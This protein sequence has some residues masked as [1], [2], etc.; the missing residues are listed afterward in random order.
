MAYI[1]CAIWE[2]R[3]RRQE[4]KAVTELIFRPRALK[5]KLPKDYSNPDKRHFGVWVQCQWSHSPTSNRDL[6]PVH[7]RWQ[8]QNFVNTKKR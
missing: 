1:I 3:V 7:A 6:D 8:V 2:N 4:N 5:R